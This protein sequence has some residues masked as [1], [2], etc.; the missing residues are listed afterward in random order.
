MCVGFRCSYVFCVDMLPQLSCVEFCISEELH[1]RNAVVK[2]APVQVMNIALTTSA[3]RW[4]LSSPKQIA[5][6]TNITDELDT[7]FLLRQLLV[8]SLDRGIHS[9]VVRGVA[10][11]VTI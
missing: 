7:L 6:P 5:V 1:G 10:R 9:I 3:A 2:Y 11:G 8:R 4:Y